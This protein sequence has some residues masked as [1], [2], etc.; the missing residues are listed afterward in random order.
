MKKFFEFV[1]TAS[2]V[3]LFSVVVFFQVPKPQKE[4]IKKPTSI[5]LSVLDHNKVFSF[6][7][8]TAYSSMAIESKINAA[9]EEQ[10]RNLKASEKAASSCETAVLLLSET[11]GQLQSKEAALEVEKQKAADAEAEKKTTARTVLIA[12]LV[13]VTIIF[14]IKSFMDPSL[15]EKKKKCLDLASTFIPVLQT[16]VAYYLS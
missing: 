6:D 7:N 15:S 12:N 13:A 4:A 3:I 1:A 8:Q 5:N 9:V 16:F 10:N 2:V 11:I 14:I